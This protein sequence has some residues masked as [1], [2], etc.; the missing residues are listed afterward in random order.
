MCNFLS[1]VLTKDKLYYHLD[2]DSHE[3]IISHFGLKDTYSPRGVTRD[4]NIVRLELTPKDSDICN[5]NLDNWQLRV[6]QD[7][8]PDW[9]DLESAEKQMKT[10]I[11]IFFKERFAINTEI[12]E[13]K[14]GFWRAILN[15]KIV[16]FCGGTIN[17]VWGGTINAVWGGTINAVWGGTIND[18]W[19][20]TINAVRG[21][22]INDVRG[23]T[24]NA[25]WGGTINAVRGGTINAVWGGT[26][27][28]VRGGTINAVRDKNA[29]KK[30]SGNCVVISHLQD[31]MRIF[32][33]LDSTKLVN[34][35]SDL[36]K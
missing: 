9:L 13:I 24:I 34:N 29:V 18:V 21:G 27:N 30:A 10:A 1:A 25:V 36:H 22:T 15:S 26:I 19:G 6:D 31:G 17:A 5:H 8:R 16:S 28:D 12:T 3:D 35:L 2:M 23:G 14:E 33:P 11:Q 4:V 7:I 20:G 32:S